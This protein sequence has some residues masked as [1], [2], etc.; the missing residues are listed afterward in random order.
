MFFGIWIF[1]AFLELCECTYFFGLHALI[2]LLRFM[3]CP[4]RSDDD[5]DDDASWSAHY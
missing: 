5:D 3:F 4:P 2:D 1:S